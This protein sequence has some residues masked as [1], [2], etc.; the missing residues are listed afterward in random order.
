M[1]KAMRFPYA[2]AKKPCGL[3]EANDTNI[4]WTDGRAGA[5][6]INHVWD[7]EGWLA[8]H[9]DANSLCS[10]LGLGVFCFVP[11]IVHTFY[12]GGYQHAFASVLKYL[13]HIWMPGSADANLVVVW[14]K[15]Q[16]SYKAHSENKLCWLCFAHHLYHIVTCMLNLIFNSLACVLLS[17][18][19]NMPTRC[20]QFR[21][22]T[23]VC[24]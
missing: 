9:S 11:D 8:A 12:L 19:R 21:F 20:A 18:H 22:A 14:S 1:A 6:W 15:L 5:D 2:P 24:C 16:A 13:T 3:C 17:A 23:N 7:D 4:P 10:L